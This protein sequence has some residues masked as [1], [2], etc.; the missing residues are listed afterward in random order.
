MCPLAIGLLIPSCACSQEEEVAFLGRG[1]N[2]D[3][4]GYIKGKAWVSCEEG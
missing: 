1:A 2:W 4:L 3:G